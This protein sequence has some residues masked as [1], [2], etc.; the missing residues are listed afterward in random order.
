M[1]DAP[2]GCGI[3]LATV[4]RAG[5]GYIGEFSAYTVFVEQSD[6]VLGT[7]RGDSVHQGPDIVRYR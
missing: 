1:A 2:W 6:Q 5:T 4:S 3:V 7:G